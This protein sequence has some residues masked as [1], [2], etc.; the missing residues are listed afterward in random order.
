[1]GIVQVKESALRVQAERKIWGYRREIRM[2]SAIGDVLFF[3][4]ASIRGHFALGEGSE[5]VLLISSS[6]VKLIRIIFLL[7]GLCFSEGH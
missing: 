6:V 4:S 5:V 3:A 7:F 1:M 2:R